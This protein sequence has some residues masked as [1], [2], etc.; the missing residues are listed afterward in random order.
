[1]SH[2]LQFDAHYTWSKTRDMGTHSNGGGQTMD[3]YDIERDYGPAIWDIP[4]RFVASYLYELPFLKNS[5]NT[6]L[7]AA[8]GGWQIGGITTLQSGSPINVTLNG[9]PANIG[10]NNQQR[11]NLVGPVPT[12]NCQPNTTG[13]TDVAR[14][15]LIDCF[16]RSAFENPAAFTFGNA[17]RNVL[18]GPKY[19]STDL[20]FMKNFPLGGGAQFQFRAEIFNAFNTVNY[21]NPGGVFSNTATFGRISSAG[22]M[23]QVQL[24][25]KF[26]F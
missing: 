25:G 24:G 9:D 21:G 3:N 20:S 6:L 12:M 26:L 2:G 16:D 1:M 8:L 19:V 11:P 18:R 4:H 17:P 15:E 13:T 7:R 5:T 22:A 23:R 10:I 14:R